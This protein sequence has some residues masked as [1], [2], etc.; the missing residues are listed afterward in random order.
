[1]RK[2]SKTHLNCGDMAAC[3]LSGPGIC[4]SS[5]VEKVDCKNCLKAIEWIDGEW[6]L[7]N[8]SEEE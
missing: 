8:P 3:G 2:G 5:S 4:F 6:V 1:M 7:K